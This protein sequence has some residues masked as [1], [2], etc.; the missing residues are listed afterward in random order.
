MDNGLMKKI[1]EGFFMILYFFVMMKCVDLL[2]TAFVHEIAV[3]NILA[4]VAAFISLIISAG[5]S[6]WT[7]RKIKE[8]L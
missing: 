8:H 3:Q 2:L 7:V 5:L 4:V 1:L 6:E